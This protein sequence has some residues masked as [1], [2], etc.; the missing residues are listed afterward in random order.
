MHPALS[1]QDIDKAL[2]GESDW[3]FMFDRTNVIALL[4]C[5][6]AQMVTG[7]RGDVISNIGNLHYQSDEFMQIFCVGYSA[8]AM[9]HGSTDGQEVQNSRP[10]SYYYPDLFYQT[11]DRV[12][13]M[14]GSSPETA[15]SYCV[16]WTKTIGAVP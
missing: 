13:S 2:N 7:V 8:Y 14:V 9:N 6:Y 12:Q 16:Q 1:V 10:L 4:F 3:K 11:V 15:I 5:P